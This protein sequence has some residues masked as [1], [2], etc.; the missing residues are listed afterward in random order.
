MAL[1]QWMVTHEWMVKPTR[2]TEWIDRR[3]LIFLTAEVFTALGV[4]L[5][6]VSLFYNNWWGMLISWIIIMFLKIPFHLH[7]LHCFDCTLSGE[8]Q[9]HIRSDLAPIRPFFL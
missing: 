6:L 5:Y 7:H 3:G 2:Q 9:P 8:I 4:G 1:R